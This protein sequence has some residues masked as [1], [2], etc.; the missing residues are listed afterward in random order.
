MTGE[1]ILKTYEQRFRDQG[2]DPDTCE[3][4]QWSRDWLAGNPGAS[5]DVF[6]S[7]LVAQRRPDWTMSALCLLWDDIPERQ[8]L[9][10]MNGAPDWALKAVCGWPVFPDG[11]SEAEKARMRQAL[12]NRRAVK[13]LE[14]LDG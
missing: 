2:G 3:G 14:R 1:E 11:L 9:I 5:G 12:T 13:A 8:R 10:L 6:F 4:V 7:A